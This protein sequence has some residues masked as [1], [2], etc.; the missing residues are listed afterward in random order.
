MRKRVV[1]SNTN[2]LEVKDLEDAEEKIMTDPRSIGKV[3]GIP[4][5]LVDRLRIV[6]AFQPTQ[7]WRM[8][9]RPAM[10]V[11]EETIQYGEMMQNLAAR[12]ESV[13]RVLVGERASGKSVMLLQAMTMAMLKGWVVISIPDGE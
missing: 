11:R 5:S 7:G 10:L 6:Q 2:A 12:Q 4:G 13:R 1:L 3:V 8:F 9:R